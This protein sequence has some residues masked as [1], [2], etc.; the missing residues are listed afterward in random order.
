[1][2]IQK[3]GILAEDL[4][5]MKF[6][7]DP[8]IS[9][10]GN[11]ILY[12]LKTTNDKQEYQAQIWLVSP[13]A[14]P[15]KLT[16]TKKADAFPRWSPKGNQIAFIS[17]R[18]GERQIWLI[19]RQG[20]EAEQLTFMRNGVSELA[21]SPDGKR[22]AFISGVKKDE[23]LELLL[24]EK[25]SEERD[26]EKTDRTKRVQIIDEFIYKSDDQGMLTDKKNHL[27]IYDFETKQC[28]QITSDRRDYR[29]PVW[30]PDGQKLVITADIDEPAYDPGKDRLILLD[31][32]SKQCTDIVLEGLYCY[33]PS[34]SPDGKKIAV[35]GHQG[36]YKGAT[37]ARI[38]ILDLQNNTWRTLALD[39]DLGVG[40][41]AM[42]D[43]RS[44]GFNPGPQWSFDGQAIFTLVSERGDTG[45][46][47]FG[48][49]DTV[50]KVVS[51]RRQIFGFSMDVDK[52]RIAFVFTTPL[53]PGDLALFDLTKQEELVL[54]E[55]NNQLLRELKLAQPE[56]FTFKTPD[57][58]ELQGWL[59]KPLDFVAGE[60]YPVVMEVHGGPHAMY[61]H[62]FFHEFQLLAAHNYGVV[63]CNPRG[64][65]GYGQ[66][67]VDA[68]RGDYGGKD[69]QD[70]LAC[71]DYALA[72]YS[73]IDETRLGVTGGSYGGYMTNWIISHTDRFKA[74]VTQRSISNWIS[75]TGVSDIGFFFSEW[76]HKLNYLQG[77]E[78]LL[79]ISP[80]KYVENIKTPL[81][82][83]HSEFDY[84]CPLEQA[85]QLYIALKK[86]RQKVRLA[87]FPGSNHDLSRNGK[88]DLR[89]ERLQQIADWFD[90][91]I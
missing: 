31:L 16:Q 65:Q 85:E 52:Q 33:L 32:A 12:V 39:H 81:L 58:W 79:E 57:G 6:V 82:I 4:Y 80:L 73:W 56:E 59:I 28:E 24:K 50:E 45:I 40:D 76:E 20:G 38:W 13:K 91:H 42:S 41:F 29:H 77:L 8:Q 86:L 43:L 68:V 69:Y 84:R 87:I 48:L 67:F 46:Y 17:N 37:L 54:T 23:A 19:D 21:W 26:Q 53:I 30:S 14:Q 47:R 22:L 44:G 66:K 9:P 61:S 34:W 70:I 10:A 18:S 78:Q 55:A 63:Y 64:G 83:I 3:R 11:E 71:V 25:T 2:V 62:S 36:E 90:Q 1:M 51:G 7:E 88:P 72:N 27:W 60:K 15:R 35:F 75:F 74:A 49:D 89:V 5:K